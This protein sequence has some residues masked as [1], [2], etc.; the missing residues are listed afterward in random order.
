MS[1]CAQE[2]GHGVLKGLQKRIAA[3]R[4][5]ISGYDRCHAEQNRR[6]KNGPQKDLVHS[7][8]AFDCCTSGVLRL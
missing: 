4:Q 7:R 5:E 2:K 3:D 8:R 6:L 1:I